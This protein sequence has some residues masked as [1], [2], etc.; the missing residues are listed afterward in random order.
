LLSEIE[1]WA[2]GCLA[3]HD[4]AHDLAH[5]RRVVANTH[6]ILNGEPEADRFVTL[7][8]AWLHDIVQLPKGTG[9]PGESARRSASEASTYLETLG[10]DAG[11]IARIADA[12]ATHSFSGGL[13]PASIEAA[14]VQDA[15]RLDALGA[16]G[17]ARLWATAAVLGSQLHH[18]DDP[19]G[20]ARELADREYGLD[21]IPVKL[22]KL[23]GLMNTATGKR[24]A[25]DRAAYVLEHYNRF[26][27]ELRGEA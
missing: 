10:I 22:L 13:R 5:V 26:L 15:D 23:P 7:A 25:A 1:Q 14:I 6:N 3:G 4:P 19:A 9:A 17:I 16:V 20:E 27:A 21:H 12:V 2:G 8:A 11:L 18:P 24:I